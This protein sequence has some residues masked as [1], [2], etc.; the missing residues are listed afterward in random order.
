MRKSKKAKDLSST[1]KTPTP[2][3][4]EGGKST[5]GKKL[6]DWLKKKEFFRMIIILAI[7]CATPL[8][9]TNLICGKSSFPIWYLWIAIP[10]AL[11]KIFDKYFGGLPK[12]FVLM[13]YLVCFTGVIKSFSHD[14]RVKDLFSSFF[15]SQTSKQWMVV[16]EKPFTGE[17]YG[18]GD[19][20]AVVVAYFSKD[21]VFQD[22][23][24]VLGK[25][26]EVWYSGK[27]N[28]HYGSYNAKSQLRSSTESYD[29]KAPEGA[30]CKIRVKRFMYPLE[31]DRLVSLSLDQ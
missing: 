11:H 22:S 15:S 27:W 23:V 16:F 17:G 28:K 25:E 30:E 7:F 14:Q 3:E 29:V 13:V 19:E 4:E 8:I 18:K 12:I 2:A 10:F 21:I 1:I 9:M 6:P 5:S 20:G 26:F 31:K 24:I